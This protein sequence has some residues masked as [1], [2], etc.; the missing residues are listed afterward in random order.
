MPMKTI[1]RVSSKS[2]AKLVGLMYAIF[3]FVFGLLMFVM[4]LFSYSE[5]TGVIGVVFGIAA[6]VFLPILYGVGGWIGGYISGGIYNLLAKRVGGIEI[7]I[8]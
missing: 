6:P 4:S 7:E 3:G 1:K 8:E 2:V 5:E